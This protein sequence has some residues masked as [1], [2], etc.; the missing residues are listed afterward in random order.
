L[1]QLKSFLNFLGY[2]KYKRFK[3]AIPYFSGQLQSLWGWLN[4]RTETDNFYYSLTEENKNYLASTIAAVTRADV[5][6]VQRFLNEIENNDQL[7][8]KIKSVLLSETHL[9]DS[10]AGLGR[11]VGWYAFIRVTKPRIVVE[12]GVHH[13]VGAL[14]ILEALKRNHQ[15]FGIVG[16]YYGTDINP[17]AGILIEGVPPES[18][19][20]LYGDSLESLKNLDETIDLFINDS[21]HSSEYEAREYAAIHDKLSKNAIILGDNS[22]VTPKLQEYSVSRNRNFLFFSEKPKGHWYPGGGIGI[23]YPK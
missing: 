18:G 3:V 11:R 17:R 9:R 14:V 23:S 6:E 22:H 16:K 1:N 15:E 21:D 5:Q 4:Q 8:T 13:G 7:E 2:R 20:I 19:E 10:Q 12:T